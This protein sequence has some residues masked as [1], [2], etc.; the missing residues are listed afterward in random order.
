[1]HSDV[2]ADER[3]V[4][5]G[6]ITS[7]S[8]GDRHRTVACA[9][10]AL[11][12]VRGSCTEGRTDT[13]AMMKNCELTKG[14]SGMEA[15]RFDRLVRVVGERRTRRATLGI[16]G[17]LVWP[18]STPDDAVAARCSPSRPCPKCRVCRKRR[19]RP[20]RNGTPC[21]RGDC[22]NGTCRCRPEGGACA[23]EGSDVCCSQ[24]CDFLVDG[25]TCSPCAG[26]GCTESADCCGG[27][28]C[29]GSSCGGCRDRASACTTAANCC[30]SNCTGGACLS[31]VGGR[32]RRD[33]DCRAC[34]VGGQ[35]AGTCSGGV[36]TR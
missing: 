13:Y 32:C 6:S 34:Y 22:R 19:C 9:D 30:F 5:S 10:A 29:V 35:C 4:C 33:V 36:C 12:R 1:M 7:H 21:G 17:A 2:L 14:E 16:L 15:A 18:G 24:A 20:A 23:T 28:T 26:R 31:A 11:Q 8:P 3:W 25:G 27:L